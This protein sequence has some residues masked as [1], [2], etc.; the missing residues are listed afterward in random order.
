MPAGQMINIILREIFQKEILMHVK[1]GMYLILF[2]SPLF[3][4]LYN[5]CSGLLRK[6]FLPK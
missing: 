1:C 2:N 6:K 5:L 4:I 3:D